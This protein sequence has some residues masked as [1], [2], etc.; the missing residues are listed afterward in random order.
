MLCPGQTLPGVYTI[1]Y[2]ILSWINYSGGEVKMMVFHNGIELPETEMYS[3]S[4]VHAHDMASRTTVTF[5]I[6]DNQLTL[7]QIKFLALGDTL[8]LQLT[9]LTNGCQ[10]TRITMCVSLNEEWL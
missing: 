8:E 6:F 1:N 9:S 10:A 3:Y 4:D 5:V 2:N 7:S